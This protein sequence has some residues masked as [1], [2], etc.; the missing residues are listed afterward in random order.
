[1]ANRIN[2]MRQKLVDELKKLGN[3]HDWSHVVKQQGMFAY[4][5]NPL[6]TYLS[7]RA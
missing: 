7:N 3:P 2:G 6:K 1:M 4:T 5:V